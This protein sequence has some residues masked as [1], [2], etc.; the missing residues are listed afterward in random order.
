MNQQPILAR[1]PLHR[2]MLAA[3]AAA[4]A[5]GLLMIGLDPAP[6]SGPA[7]PASAEVSPVTVFLQPRRV[8]PG[9]EPAA[10][11]IERRRPPRRTGSTEATAIAARP[12][13]VAQSEMKF[14]P[15]PDQ[16]VAL[17]E[18][19]A[20]AEQ[21]ASAPSPTLSRERLRLDAEVL[22]SA[23]T[24]SRG[25]VRAMADAAGRSTE[26]LDSGSQSR[27]SRAVGS[28]GRADC[29]AA[30]EHASLLSAVSIV[31]RAVSGRCP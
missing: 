11:K 21:T 17:P 10:K 8:E 23:A 25:S 14:L 2:R 1:Q 22:R 12:P 27:W 20:I 30:D 16:S 3:A 29:L 15:I 18:Q 13:P 4:S 9:P 31:A 26:N 28:A 19:A 24:T 7:S 6:Q 5:T